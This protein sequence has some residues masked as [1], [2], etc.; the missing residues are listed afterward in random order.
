MDHRGITA[1]AGALGVAHGLMRRPTPWCLTNASHRE[2]AKLDQKAG[3]N[4]SLS[5]DGTTIATIE[6]SAK[7]QQIHLISLTGQ[8]QRTIAL[9]DWNNL[10]SLD[11]DAGGVGFFISSNP[12][13]HLSTLLYVELAGNAHSLW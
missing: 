5:P 11:W 8:A 2:V 1:L 12:T 7:N 3:W 13:G 10:R 9:K 6:F 4:W